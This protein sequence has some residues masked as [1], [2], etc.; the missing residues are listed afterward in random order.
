ML[1]K[2]ACIT[3]E[4][5]DVAGK[6]CICSSAYMIE[7]NRSVMRLKLKL[8]DVV[9]QATAA[10]VRWANEWCVCLYISVKNSLVSSQIF[11]SGLFLP[12]PH[13]PKRLLS[14]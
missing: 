11:V 12:S 2:P 13:P 1:K 9:V 14:S 3:V 6:V 5:C 10:I 4:F 8:L 7:L